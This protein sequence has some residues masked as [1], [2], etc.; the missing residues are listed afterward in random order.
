MKPG[1]QQHQVHIG[2]VIRNA[3]VFNF[4]E[5]PGDEMNTDTLV[6]TVARLFRLL[7]EREIEYALVGGIALLQ[8]VEGR[9][10]DDIDLVLAPSSLERLPEI[11]IASKDAD[12][13]RGSFGVVR[14]DLLLTSNSLFEKVRQSYVTTQRFIEQEVPCATVEGL[15]LTKMYALPSLYRQGSF[16][17]VGLYENDI[18]TL[19]HDYK[20]N[21]EP[22]LKELALHLSATDVAEIHRIIAEIHE[23]IERFEEGS[24]RS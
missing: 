5:K 9:N 21:L 23:R 16:A 4:R 14:V 20:P 15:L 11:L 24:T 7:S 2:E 13:A 18:A 6:E 8:Y 1:T 3:V 12:F 19:I 22:L 17:R 10:T